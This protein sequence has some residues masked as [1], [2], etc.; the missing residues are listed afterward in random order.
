MDIVSGVPVTKKNR[1]KHEN[2]GL[3]GTDVVGVPAKEQAFK[4]RSMNFFRLWF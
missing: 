1:V 4:Q 3:K 2:F